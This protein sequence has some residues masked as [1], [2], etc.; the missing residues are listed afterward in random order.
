MRIF[1][2]SR[3]PEK[4]LASPADETPSPPCDAQPEEIDV[5]ITVERIEAATTMPVNQINHKWAGLRSFF[6]DRTPV[7]G[8]DPSAKGFF[9]ASWTRGVWDH[10]FASHGAGGNGASDPAVVARQP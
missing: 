9:L 6:A 8:F 5:A 1:I 3:K 7:V 4:I 10:D 2:S